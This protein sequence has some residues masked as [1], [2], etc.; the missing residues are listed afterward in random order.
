MEGK[1]I[2]WERFASWAPRGDTIS[3]MSDLDRYQVP[4]PTIHCASD[5]AAGGREITKAAFNLHL[6]GRGRIL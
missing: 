6:G 4:H 2:L 3:I 1:C 5:G